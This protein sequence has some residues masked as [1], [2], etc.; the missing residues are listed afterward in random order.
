MSDSNRNKRTPQAVSPTPL[1]D[2]IARQS[3]AIQMALVGLFALCIVCGGKVS[4]GF[5][6][7]NVPANL[8]LLFVMLSGIILGSR[9]GMISALA[10]LLVASMIDILWPLN[11]GS[12]PMTGLLAGYLWSLPIAA[13]ASGKV[14]EKLKFETFSSYMMASLIGVA[15]Y[16]TIGSVR[17]IATMDT[18]AMWTAVN[19]TTTILGFHL[20]HAFV[21]TIAGIGASTAARV[22]N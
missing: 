1:R 8:Q 22:R 16:E 7:T 4:L 2:W 17:L 18:E 12:A 15:V 14:V 13:Y 11:V 21:V 9:L 20:A 3:I 19:G 10:Y 6:G 5:A